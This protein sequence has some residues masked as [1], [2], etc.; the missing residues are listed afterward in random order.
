MS[1]LPQYMQ[2]I[3]W[4][5]ARADHKPDF[6]T[7]HSEQAPGQ[8]LN[9]GRALFAQACLADPATELTAF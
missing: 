7:K 5:Y 1:T 3:R 4:H 9:P 8:L 2:L 6:I